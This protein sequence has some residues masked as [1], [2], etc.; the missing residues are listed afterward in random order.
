MSSNQLVLLLFLNVSAIQVFG[1][2]GSEK[3]IYSCEECQ[4][5]AIGCYDLNGDSRVDILAYSHASNTVEW[6]ENLGEGLFS[7]TKIIS[8]QID[9]FNNF[10]ATDID[11]DNDLDIIKGYYYPSGASIYS[12]N[13]R[14]SY[15]LNNGFG[16]FS[17][18]KIV[19]VEEIEGAGIYPSMGDLDGDGDVDLVFGL[20]S[21][22]IWYENLGQN[23]FSEKKII[24]LE[25]YELSSINTADIDNDG[26]MDMFTTHY[27]GSTIWW[28][29][30]GNNNFSSEG[31]TILNTSH[32]FGAI[33]TVPIDIDG[34]NDLDFITGGDVTEEIF[35]SK[36]D[37]KGNFDNQEKQ[38]LDFVEDVTSIFS[39][40][41]DND[42]DNDILYTSGAGNTIYWHENDGLG[43]FSVKK[44]IA[45]NVN[46][47]KCIFTDD[48]D[49]DGHNEVLFASQSFYKIS[50]L[51]TDFTGTTSIDDLGKKEEIKI[52]PNPFQDF[53]SIEQENDSSYIFYLFNS[54]GQQ[55]YSHTLNST[56]QQIPATHLPNGLHLYQVI[57]VD[58]QMMANGKVIKH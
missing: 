37:G 42:G 7:E 9:G 31:K 16:E 41:L 49:N 46:R 6:Y 56:I 15:F 25:A 40:D 53:I 2:F 14:V 11:N 17:E 33:I 10:I 51:D 34:D 1:Q 43:N 38:I 28:E 30:K 44:I 24:S 47:P 12:Y 39:S 4:A 19:I 20:Q 50:I 45:E 48:I 8:E 22:I 55:V 26:D 29:N 52:S 3:V 36:N 58:G 54:K 27:Y 35:L 21:S 18:E 32:F 5:A 57:N 13:I 23:S